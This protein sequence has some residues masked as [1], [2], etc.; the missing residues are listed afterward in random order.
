MP[1]IPLPVEPADVDPVPVVPIPPPMAAS[2]E[3]YPE[4]VRGNARP[5]MISAIG[6][7]SLVVASIS[8]LGGFIMLMINMVFSSMARVM[9]SP[10][11]S[12]PA[13]I[14]P[15]PA[16]LLGPNGTAAADRALIVDG[17]G[18]VRPL[19]ELQKQ[20]FDELLAEEGKSILPLSGPGITPEQVIAN[21]TRSGHLSGGGE[22]TDYFVLGDGRLELT[23]DRAVFFPNNGQPSIRAKAIDIPAGSGGVLQPDQIRSAIRAIDRTNGANIKSAQ[24]RALVKTLEGPGQQLV[25]PTSDGSDPANEITAAS[26]DPADGSL[27]LTT[28][29]GT[30][31]SSITMDRFG[32]I[33]SSSTTS[34]TTTSYS[35]SVTSTA[36]TF[37]PARPSFNR[38]ASQWLSFLSVLQLTLAVYLLI[39]GIFMLRHGSFVGRRMHWIYV[40]FKLPIAI[41]TAA[42]AWWLWNGFFTQAASN[43]TSGTTAAMPFWFVL[44]PAIGMIYPVVLLFVLGMNKGVKAYFSV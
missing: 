32:A 15:G 20:Q 38:N 25:A 36:G 16:E 5:G 7:T 35:M 13:M 10:V 17:L 37:R 43:P 12:V 11:P 41:A 4:L 29:H 22:A 23:D 18:Q 3:S 9:P 14:A 24:A 42:V 28:H 33:T 21:V 44:P 26:T 8:L 19:R 27:T 1:V 39:C 40:G 34:A 6:V 30:T 2:Y 31:D